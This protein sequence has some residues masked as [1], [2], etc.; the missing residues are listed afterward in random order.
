MLRVVTVGG[1]ATATD[2]VVLAVLYYGYALSA[3]KAAV[4]GSLVGGAVNFL[5]N[6]SWVFGATAGT[7]WRQAV[8]YATIVVG[9]GAVLGGGVV[10][11]LHAFGIPVL[12]AKCAAIGL[13][14]VTWTYPM[15][16]RVVFRD[17]AR[18]PRAAGSSPQLVSRSA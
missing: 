14:L 9:G 1:I 16:A 12:L 13:V 17:A 15:S 10:A 4:V 3:A 5:L 8:L 2:T 11:G 18:R 6:R 7:W